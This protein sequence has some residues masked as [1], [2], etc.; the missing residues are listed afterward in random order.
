MDNI[1]LKQTVYR[2]ITSVMSF[3]NFENTISLNIS[4]QTIL[5]LKLSNSIYTNIIY[6]LISQYIM[7]TFINVNESNEVLLHHFINYSGIIF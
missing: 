4:Y 1:N 7:I 2:F 6:I 3:L 5:S